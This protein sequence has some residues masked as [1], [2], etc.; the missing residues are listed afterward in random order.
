MIRQ[1]PR[2]PAVLLTAQILQ[3]AMAVVFLSVEQESFIWDIEV[4]PVQLSTRKKSVRVEST[5]TI[6]NMK[7]VMVSV[8]VVLL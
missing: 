8:A 7:Q 2:R 3:Q 4:K 5:I 1:L 6:V